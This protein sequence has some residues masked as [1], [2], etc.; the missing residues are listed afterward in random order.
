MKI[1][2]ISYCAHSLNPRVTKYLT[3]FALPIPQLSPG[4]TV[5]NTLTAAMET[6]KCR[7]LYDS[8]IHVVGR[9]SD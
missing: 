1:I 4:H 5:S 9:Q 6:M 7:Y 3:N 2:I 8:V